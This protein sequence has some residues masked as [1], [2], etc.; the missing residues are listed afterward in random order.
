LRWHRTT[1][2]RLATMDAVVN[3]ADE[4]S[5]SDKILMNFSPITGVLPA[6]LCRAGYMLGFATHS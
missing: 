1:D 4:P 5:T 2:G 3:T 6:H